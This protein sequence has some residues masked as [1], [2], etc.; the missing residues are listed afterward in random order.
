[1]AI[2]YKLSIQNMEVIPSE[3]D[4]QNVVKTVHWMYSGTENGDNIKYFG[5]ISGGIEVNSASAD[6]FTAFDDLTEEQVKGWVESQI[7]ED[8]LKPSIASQIESQKN[9]P[10]VV[11]SNPWGGEDEV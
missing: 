7:D 5:Q 10:T 8:S 11:K 9:P 4:L 2:E 6:S 3:G 1:M